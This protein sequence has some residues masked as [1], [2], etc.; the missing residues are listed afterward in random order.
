M[1]QVQVSPLADSSTR[2]QQEIES[3][4]RQIRTDGYPMSISEWISMYDANELDIHPEFQRFFRWEIAQ[5]TALIESILL[6][7]PIPPIFV[8]QRA[9]GVWDVIDG[10]Q[11]LSTV[12]QFI[13]ILKDVEGKFV[14]ALALNRTNYLPSLGGIMWNS[15]VQEECL[16][17]DL[18]L[19][20]KRTKIQA[21]I[22]LRES[23]D[24]TKY[25][26]FER[27]NTGGSQLSAQEVRN[28]V[29]VML[30]P[31]M[32]RWIKSLAKHESFVRCTALS[33][34]AIA[35]AYDLELVLRFLVLA[36]IDESE[37]KNVGDVGI[38]LSE[39]MKAMAVDETFERTE[40]E[41]IFTQTFDLLLR[42]MES[43][44]FKRFNPQKNQHQGGFLVSQFEVVALGVGYNFPNLKP[45]VEIPA[46]VASIWT[47]ADYTEWSRS[48]I[49]AT[50]RLP[51]LIP[52]G[53]KLFA[54]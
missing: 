20:F 54:L 40:F 14:D 4:R 5:K 6:G 31:S 2:L 17:P 9:D 38:F 52:L 42:T 8:S 51:R 19:I 28:C 44:A 33:D 48:G 37:L 12:F 53:R 47:N 43:D 1:S 26:L 34:S 18:K 23:D 22:V 30:N 10:V 39:K 7:I 29:L 50:R 16:P 46:L 41:E 24:S 25:D 36:R 21:S 27:L 3:K 11:R 49:T 13:G 45:E 32:Y 15:Q 35:E